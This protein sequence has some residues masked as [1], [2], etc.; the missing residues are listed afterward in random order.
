MKKTLPLLATFLIVLVGC[1][2]S[3]KEAAETEKAHIL[4]S[5]SKVKTQQTIDS[6]KNVNAAL[7][8]ATPEE[9]KKEAEEEAKRIADS[10]ATAIQNAIDADAAK[11]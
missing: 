1:G 9:Q 8:E 5:L 6:L 2:Q 3:A 10:L 11:K 4:D 7:K